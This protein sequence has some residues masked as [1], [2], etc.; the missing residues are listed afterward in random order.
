MQDEVGWLVVVFLGALVWTMQL[1]STNCI[2]VMCALDI[3]LRRSDHN[4][5]WGRHALVD[6]LAWE[7]CRTENGLWSRYYA[8]RQ[9]KFVRLGLKEI[10]FPFHYCAIV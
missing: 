5:R 1:A 2:I 4:P 10:W 3:I 7:C 8:H 6:D 9:V